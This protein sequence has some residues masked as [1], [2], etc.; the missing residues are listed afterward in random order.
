MLARAQERK[1]RDGEAVGA[2]EVRVESRLD[3]AEVR[4]HAGHAP[5]RAHARVVHEHV[6]PAGILGH[7]G[8]RALDAR[9]VGHVEHQRAR[10]DGLG[11]LTGLGL[12]ARA[13]DDVVAALDQLARGLAADS[14]IGAGHEGH[15]HGASLPGTEAYLLSAPGYAFLGEST[16]EVGGSAQGSELSRS[17]APWH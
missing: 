1:Q 8:G 10:A 16:R 5:I 3:G 17:S 9:R 12:V 4:V 6:E 2:E 11:G 14:P 15:C 13:Q 7:L